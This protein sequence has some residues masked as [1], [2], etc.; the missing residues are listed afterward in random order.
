MKYEVVEAQFKDLEVLPNGDI[1]N[2]LAINKFNPNNFPTNK[3]FTLDREGD[4][5]T[6]K[7]ENNTFKPEV[8]ALPNLITN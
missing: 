7:E 2:R 3:D 1:Y 4:C 8:A 5:N 6:S